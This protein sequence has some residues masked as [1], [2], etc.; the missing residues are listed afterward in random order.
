MYVHTNIRHVHE[1]QRVVTSLQFA[2][3]LNANIVKIEQ[4][5]LVESQFS[6]T[7]SSQTKIKLFAKRLPFCNY[8]RDCDR[9]SRGQNPYVEQFL[10]KTFPL[11]QLPTRVPLF[12]HFLT[13]PR[14]SFQLCLTTVTI[15]FEF[16]RGKWIH[17]TRIHCRIFHGYV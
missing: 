3:T 12:F 13:Q 11:N 8:R 16:V 6:R 4:S 9:E 5:P 15:G 2:S 1:R 7:K 17:G 14:F 10:R